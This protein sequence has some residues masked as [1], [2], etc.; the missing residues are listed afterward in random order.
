[1]MNSMAEMMKNPDMMKQMEEMMKN[2]DIMSNA[3]KM[4]NDPSMAN[5]FGGGM[6]NMPNLNPDSEH[7]EEEDGNL[8]NHQESNEEEVISSKFSVN[9]RVKLV[10]LKSDSYNGE[11]CVIK[12]FDASTNRYNVLVSS[13][14][15]VISVKEENIEGNEDIVVEVD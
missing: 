9:Q 14:N 3:M 8:E 5:L 6:P 11:E 1:M 15:K 13:L 2:P 7:N 12:L 10:N 4:M